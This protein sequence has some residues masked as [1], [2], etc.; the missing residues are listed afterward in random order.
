MS[1]M[2]QLYQTYEDHLSTGHRDADSITPIAHMNAKA[3]L[4]VTINET[5]DFCQAKILDDEAS[6]TLIPVTEKSAG[7]TSKEEPHPLNDMLPYVA[8]DFAKHCSDETKRVRAE[9]KFA[10]YIESLKSWDQSDFSHPKVHAVYLYLQ[11]GELISDLVKSGIV[12]LET[13][14]TF[15]DK[16]ISG[17]P[18]ENVLV[19]F[20]ILEAV[21]NQ[22]SG[23]WED[24]TLI[25]KYIDFYLSQADGRMDICYLTGEKGLISENHPK[26]VVAANYGAKLISANDSNGYTYRG[27]FQDS[28]QAYALS[29]E[30]SQ[31][32]HSALTWLIKRQGVYVENKDKR[33]RKKETEVSIRTFVCWNP[34]GKST[35][36]ILNA[37]GLVN[38]GTPD[39]S[40]SYY[41]QKLKKMLQGYRDQFDEGDQII[42]MGFDAATTGRL[43]ITYY[44]EYNAFGFLDRIEYW[45]KTCNW[46]FKLS[47]E[48]NPFYEVETPSF[49]K[50]V[51]CA[52]GRQE[53]EKIEVDDRILKEQTQRLLKCMLEKRPIPS[54]IVQALVERA[55]TP[56]AYSNLN[57]ELV[58]STACAVVSKR[59][60]ELFSKGDENQMKLDMENHDRS[61]LFGRLLAVLEK[62]EKVAYD[63]GEERETNAI[64]L[65][66]AYVNHPMQTWEVLDDALR[67]YFQKLKPG[68][69]EYYKGMI[70]DIIGLITE[71][72]ESSLNQRLKDTYL[73]G[74]YLQRAELNKKKEE[75]SNE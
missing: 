15:C 13:D 26:G 14:G 50:I 10:S 68:T 73:L 37:F 34:K 5:G 74:Y 64:R 16:K 42:V 59:Q 12:E 57:R 65:Q 47:A 28:K 69:R 75:K 55:S 58:L 29:Y 36:D 1:W 38:D 66:S 41:R 11:K 6:L 51:Q 52:F 49:Y 4:E 24:D 44:N 67:P 23:T 17:K 8:E 27:R 48:K 35:P 62:V 71:Q 46:N 72:D 32:I 40:G 20:R 31:K 63:S 30:S 54:D 3:Q 56:L 18:Y 19:R 9:K 61:Y 43:S 22:Y 25:Q 60:Y 45:G 2:S 21:D 7:R 33:V 39:E 70:S 53:N